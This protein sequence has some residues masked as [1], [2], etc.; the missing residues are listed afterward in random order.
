RYRAR[1]I[2]LWVIS[3]AVMGTFYFVTAWTPQLLTRVGMTEEQGITVATLL[4][5]GGIIGTLAF[6]FLSTKWDV[7]RVS[8]IFLFAS[9]ALSIVF[10]VS[11][12]ILVAAM[13]AGLALGI[14]TGA[15]SSI[16]YSLTPMTYPES[17]RATGAGAASTVGRITTIVAPML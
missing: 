15:T 7:R 10:S 9:A 8:S 3:L 13:L 6:G 17:I 1:T 16:F 4:L 5:S 11:S 12:Q 2:R 14:V